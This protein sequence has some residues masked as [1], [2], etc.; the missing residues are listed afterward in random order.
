MVRTWDLVRERYAAYD[1]VLPS[2]PRF[3][4]QA[5]E[6]S[7]HCCKV[8]TVALNESEAERMVRES[9][10]PRSAF[11]ETEDGEPIVLPLADPYV[12]KRGPGCC[13]LLGDDLLCSQYEGRPDACRLYPH[14]VLFVDTESGRPV[15]PDPD[16]FR[17][18]IGGA[19]DNPMPLLLR[20]LECPGFTGEP[21]GDD[22]WYG[23]LE[24]TYRLQYHD[25]EPFHWPARR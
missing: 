10:L 25:R 12:L 4:C 17:R 19:A 15:G 18:V 22:A 16:A 20:H 2:T 13:A 21:L 9:G 23:L 24:E 5:A 3:I 14:Q 1:L 11:L 6:C 7:A 8:F